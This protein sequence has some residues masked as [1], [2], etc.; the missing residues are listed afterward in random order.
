MAA[1][2]PDYGISRN[3]PFTPE[4]HERFSLHNAKKKNVT[5]V[6]AISNLNQPQVVDPMAL[7]IGSRSNTPSDN[8]IHIAKTRA[9]KVENQNM[10]SAQAIER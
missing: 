9:A 2:K 4:F 7:L 10:P 8:S 3:A 6:A 1:E 5:T